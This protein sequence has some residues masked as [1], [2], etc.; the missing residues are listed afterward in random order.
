MPFFNFDMYSKRT[1]FFFNNEEKISS[2]FGFFLTLVYILTSISLFI[3]QILIVI[4][5][6]ELNVYDSTIYAQEMPSMTVDSDQLYFAFGL[7]DPKTQL[8]LLMTQYIY[9]K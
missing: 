5:R 9:Q 1:S 4:R 7:E 6:E 2:Y 3:Y 8:D